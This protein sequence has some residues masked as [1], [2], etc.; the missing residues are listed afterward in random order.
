MNALAR[1]A[2][3]GILSGIKEGL[4]NDTLSLFDEDPQQ[5]DVSDNVLSG[6]INGVLFQTT[7]EALSV[8]DQEQMQALELAARSAT[9]AENLKNAITPDRA[10]FISD[11]CMSQEA[12]TDRPEITKICDTDRVFV[13]KARILKTIS[14]KEADNFG[15]ILPK[16]VTETAEKN[17]Q[18]KIKPLIIRCYGVSSGDTV[19][20]ALTGADV[21]LNNRPAIIEDANAAI[22]K[23]INTVSSKD[24]ANT[25]T[26]PFITGQSLGGMFASVIALKN[27]FGSAVFNP[28]GLNDKI[29]EYI[30]I[31]ALKEAKQNIN[32]HLVIS[33]DGDFT[34]SPNSVLP[35]R[36]LFGGVMPGQTITIPASDDKDL[37]NIHMGYR[38]AFDAACKD[39]F[40]ANAPK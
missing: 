14:I 7:Q 3:K 24:D 15:L 6:V 9:K 37:Y 12:F 36:T 22:V 25:I 38:K 20:Q 18:L 26:V 40:A 17:K 16:K 35:L 32:K 11:E 28:L 5:T 13:A 23:Y 19:N 30:G 39:A 34:S 4:D 8:I 27:N 10:K 1:I 33:L 2:L 29:C 21:L 31:D